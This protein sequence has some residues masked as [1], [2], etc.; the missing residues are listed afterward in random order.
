MN[1]EEAR[2][3][4]RATLARAGHD[5]AAFEDIDLTP[6]PD[7]LD[8]VLAHAADRLMQVQWESYN[9]GLRVPGR[10]ERASARGGPD[11]GGA[12]PRE[13]PRNAARLAPRLAEIAVTITVL[14]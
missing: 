9:E 14:R 3:E 11:P 5:P 2:A 7:P 8:A 12:L 13:H 1:H 10:R 6:K 4:F